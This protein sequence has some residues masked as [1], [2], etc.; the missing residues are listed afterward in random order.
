MSESFE[1][2]TCDSN[3]LT[4]S[5]YPSDKV[6]VVQEKIS[7]VPKDEQIKLNDDTIYRFFCSVKD[8]CLFLKLYEIGVFAPYIYEIFL[9]LDK[10]REINSMFNACDTIE[11]VRDNINILFKNGK[12]KLSK[13]NDNTITLNITALLLAKVETFKIELERKITSEKDDTLIKLYEI[14]KKEIKL[15]KEMEKLLKGKGGKGNSLLSKM[16]DI[17]KKY[18]KI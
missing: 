2:I 4:T 8:N 14:Q 9:S 17:Q 6:E 18:D 16:F 15:W 7:D 1:V 3:N 10:M 13:E 11:E 12:I 5:V